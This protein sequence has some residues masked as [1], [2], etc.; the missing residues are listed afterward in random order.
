MDVL[1]FFKERTRFIRQFYDTAAAPFIQTMEAIEKGAPPFDDPPY[2]EDGE[3]AYLVEWIK[4]SEALEVLGRTCLSMLSPS[5]QLYFRTWERQLGIRWDEGERNRAFK[6]GFLN[7]YLTCFEQ[8]SGIVR[9]DCPADLDLIEQF[10][11][12]RNRDQHPEDITSMRVT[13]GRVKTD[14]PGN[15]FFMSET[16]RAM[17]RDPEMQKLSFL[18]PAVHVSGEQLFAA[19]LEAENLVDWL[20]ATLL[21]TRWGSRMP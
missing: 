18:D 16:D 4:A 11:L 17:F 19:I 3:P 12:A 2:S 8:V 21:K 15:Q 13:H 1:F 5:L 20:E 7:G 6:K 9:K 10:I 14:T